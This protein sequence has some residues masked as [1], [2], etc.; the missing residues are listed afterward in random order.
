MSKRFATLQS[1]V[2]R[3]S[4]LTVDKLDVVPDGNSK[5]GRVDVVPLTHREVRQIAR[6]LKFV[7]KK[8]TELAKPGPIRERAKD[9]V[10]EVKLGATQV[11]TPVLYKR[12]YYKIWVYAT[13]ID[14]RQDYLGD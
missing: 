14:S 7:I 1:V 5:G 12:Y 4:N 3:R 11:R 6:Y 8:G 9:N 2:C 13:R 10:I